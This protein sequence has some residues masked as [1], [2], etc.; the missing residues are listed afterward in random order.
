MKKT[1]SYKTLRLHPVYRFQVHE[2]VENIRMELEE[3]IEKSNWLDEESKKLSK[4]KL[5]S[6]KIF[7]GFPDWYKN[8]TALINLYKGVCSILLD[9]QKTKIVI[10]GVKNFEL[11][12]QIILF[13]SYQS[14]L[15]IST[16]L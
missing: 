10:M 15:I 4:D 2:M 8:R 3:K 5:N 7:I 12:M 1:A 14:V 16:M 6:M 9:I 11:T 13:D